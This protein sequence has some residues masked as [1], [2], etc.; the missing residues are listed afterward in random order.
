MVGDHGRAEDITQDVFI[1]ALRRLRETDRPVAFKPWIY[2][3]ARNA[4]IDDFRRRRRAQEVSLEV[5]GGRR[6]RRRAAGN[7]PRPAPEVAIENKQRA[8][9]SPRRLPGTLGGP[10]PDHGHAR[11]RGSQLRADRRAHGDEQAGGGEHAVPGPPAPARGIRRAGQRPPLR[12]GA[13]DD[14]GRAASDRCAPWAPASV[15]SSRVICRTASRAGAP[16]GW[17]ASTSPSS[18]LR[19]WSGRSRR[20]CRSRGCDCGGVL[21]AP[22][23]SDSLAAS[24]GPHPL[25]V[26]RPLQALA[27]FADP[28]GPL[29]GL[30]RAATAAAATIVVAG[31][32]GGIVAG[33]ASQPQHPHHS[34]AAVSAPTLSVAAA[35]ARR[36]AA[37]RTLQRSRPGPHGRRCAE[38]RR[39]QDG[40]GRR[41][42]APG[43]CEVGRWCNASADQGARGPSVE[44]ADR[45]R[46]GRGGQA[47][48]GRFLRSRAAGWGDSRRTVATEAP[49][50]RAPDCAIDH[51]H[52]EEHPGTLAGGG[53]TCRFPGF[54]SRRLHCRIRAGTF[55]R[56]ATTRAEG[57][58]HRG[59]VGYWVHRG[60][61]QPGSAHRSGR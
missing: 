35:R 54:S 60:V 39:N 59:P 21:A 6:S 57:R 52:A 8:G 10:S 44:W 15:A 28:S 19:V 61:A 1:A 46:S 48:G 22:R 33:L 25:S 5:L 55:L 32:G 53:Q 4:C 12:A 40:G 7:H 16:P 49:D 38:P 11:A 58:L 56:S 45:R 9:R 3:I 29:T 36:V 14:R 43:G 2:E 50:G 31:A 13:D 26:W 47:R 27:Q 30:G 37:A 24:A 20:C 23:E 18:T 17:P 41:S 34:A 51:E 42:E